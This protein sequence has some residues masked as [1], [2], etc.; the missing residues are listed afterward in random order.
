MGLNFACITKDVVSGV[1]AI[2][3]LANFFIN[4][5]HNQQSSTDFYLVHGTEDSV[6]GYQQ[7]GN[8]LQKLTSYNN[9]NE[10]SVVESER[11]GRFATDIES[12]EQCNG[13]S[14]VSLFTLNGAGHTTPIAPGLV[15]EIVGRILE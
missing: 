6:I 11:F 5:C 14:K 15:E 12:F 13:G 7:A 1:V 9:C 2:G 10:N 3:G 4:S 8:S